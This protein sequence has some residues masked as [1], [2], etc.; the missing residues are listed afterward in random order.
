MLLP[1]LAVAAAGPD[2][3]A[4]AETPD[5]SRQALLCRLQL[6]A[7]PA[8]PPP[9]R[10]PALRLR[11]R[12]ET[13]PPPPLLEA[14][15][16]QSRLEQA[17]TAL[18]SQT[19]LV[20]R[21]YRSITLDYLGA[22]ENPADERLLPLR[23]YPEFQSR[24]AQLLDPLRQLRREILAL[25]Q[26]RNEKEPNTP[27]EALTALIQEKYPCAVSVSRAP[28][29][30]E[31]MQSPLRRRYAEVAV[32]TYRNAWELCRQVNQD[33]ANGLRLPPFPLP[34]SSVPHAGYRRKQPPQPVNSPRRPPRQPGIS[35]P[36]DRLAQRKIR[37]G[38]IY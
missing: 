25:L 11:P 18:Q 19:R 6:P 7:L 3:A 38:R 21:Y 29:L 16:W 30:E 15:A 2:P 12:P 33:Q 24:L 36:I 28:T 9:P 8:G 26:E 4:A 14:A 17:E 35:D 20:N 32:L 31:F 13:E 5:L 10:R 27:P 1:Q 34:A 23:H 22:S 37:Q